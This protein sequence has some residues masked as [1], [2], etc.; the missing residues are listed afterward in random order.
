MLLP[1]PPGREPISRW[2]VGAVVAAAVL[3]RAVYLAQLHAECPTFDAPEGGDSIFYNRVAQHG[4]AS[5]RAFFHSPLYQGWLTLLYQVLGRDLL[6]V[7][8]LQLGLG[9][10][11]A[12]LVAALGWRLT[13]RRSVALLAG[14]VQA[15]LG[16]A[17]FYEGHLLVDALMPLA[18]VGAAHGALSLA[19]RP[20]PA[21]GLVAGL[22]IGVAATGR[23]TALLWL[24]VLLVWSLRRSRSWALAGALL[25]GAALPILPVTMLNLVAEDDPVLLTSN[26]GLNLFIGNGPD[27]SGAY[28]PPRELRFVP[29]DPHGDFAGREAAEQDVGGPLSSAAVSRWWARRALDAVVADPLRALELVVAKAR[30]L[31]SAREQPQLYHIEGYEQVAPVLGLLPGAGPVVA[32]GLVGLL[33]LFAG[34]HG[35]R[36]RLY[37]WCV[38]ATAAAFL[39]FFVV[40][41]FRA[42]WV[43]LLAPLAAWVL[44]TLARAL[45]TGA[46]RRAA[47]L[48][49]G[50]VA[51]AAVVWAPGPPVPPAAQLAA[52]ADGELA[53]DR[54]SEALRWGTLA[55]DEVVTWPRGWLITAVALRRLGRLDEARGALRRGVSVCPESGALHRALGEAELERGRPAEAARALERAVELEPGVPAAWEALAVALRGEGRWGE[56]REA[57]RSAALLRS[58]AP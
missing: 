40:G 24:P 39:P 21:T 45:A 38:V 17:V 8:G 25:A 4:G 19:E 14:L 32:L 28:V 27:A 6:V 43:S 7:R 31:V 3:P 5:D 2:V 36:M 58:S 35:E 29:G 16:P 47:A 48:V 41:R 42:P 30:L 54:P 49:G 50:V 23:A 13:G 33:L 46:W 1:P 22:L 10:A 15:L 52:F 34:P 57:R 26:A 44:V 20:R 37:G 18:L 51:S 53:R 11:T 9:A 56:A 12:A 55:V